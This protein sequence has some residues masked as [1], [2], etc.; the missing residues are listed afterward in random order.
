MNYNDCLLCNDAP[1]RKAC[2]VFDPDRL[3]RSLYFENEDVVRNRLNGSIPCLHCDGRCRKA[4]PMGVDMLDD[5]R[6]RENGT[7]CI[8]CLECVKN[9]P[10]GAL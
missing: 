9:C 3:L 8:L 2:G 10:K 1:C 6:K 5:S 4:C 7:E